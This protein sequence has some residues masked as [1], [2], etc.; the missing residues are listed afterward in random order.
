MGLF[1]LGKNKININDAVNII[2]DNPSAQLI[3]VREPDEYAS[4]HIPGSVNIPVGKIG[5][6]DITDKYAQIYV[7]CAS[8]MRSKMAA[9][10]LKDNGFT[11]VTNIGGI[12]SYR[13]P[14]E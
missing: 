4:G 5:G 13:G 9:K 8:G 10:I 6:A 12:M 11:D 1:G 14:L 2:R 7:Y 3:D